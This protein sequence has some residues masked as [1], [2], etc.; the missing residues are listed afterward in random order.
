MDSCINPQI[1]GATRLAAIKKIYVRD[2]SELRIGCVY[3][4]PYGDSVVGHTYYRARLEKVYGD[5]AGCTVKVTFLVDG[6]LL[7]E[8]AHRANLVVWQR[9][10][11]S[12]NLCHS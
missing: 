2:A 3:L 1:E 6:N 10:K 4:A 7:P 11:R 5:G 12:Y 9:T 8:V